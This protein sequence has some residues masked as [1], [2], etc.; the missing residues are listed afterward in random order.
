MLIIALRCKWTFHVNMLK[1]YNFRSPPGG[2]NPG[3]IAD[4]SGIP[5]VTSDSQT[6]TQVAAA[7]ACV[8]EDCE[9]DDLTAKDSDF[10]PL[11]NLQQKETIDDV[12]INP[13]LSETQKQEVRALLEE[14]RE[15]FSDIPKVMHLAEHK[16]EPVRCKGYPIPYQLEQVINKE[17]DDMLAMG[18]IERSDAAYASPIVMVKKSDGTY[19][20][21]VNFKELNKITVFDP[22]SMML[23]D[24]IFPKLSGSKFYSTFDF[25]KGYWAIPMEEGSKDCTSFITPRGL[26]RFRTM[27]FGMVNAGRTYA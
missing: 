4:I 26:M 27:P 19:R 20:M 8:L 24:D 17:L 1:K 12:L 25:C 10:L 16:S 2:D 9:G 11:Y 15:I 7:V 22:E 14:Y 13:E 3:S 5:L 18:I 6:S 21:R 23:A